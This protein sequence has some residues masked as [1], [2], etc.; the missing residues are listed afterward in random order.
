MLPDKAHKVA[1]YAVGAE[2]AGILDTVT[3]THAA[4]Q[5]C[6]SCSKIADVMNWCSVLA[7]MPDKTC[8]PIQKF[9]CHAA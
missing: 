4:E 2:K 3:K 1:R 8:T 9:D 7:C 6:M 5:S